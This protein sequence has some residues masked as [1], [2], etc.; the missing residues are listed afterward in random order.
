MYPKPQCSIYPEIVEAQRYLVHLFG[1]MN[2]LT[3]QYSA[4][5]IISPELSILRIAV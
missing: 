3:H 5:A 4:Q 2:S 1:Y